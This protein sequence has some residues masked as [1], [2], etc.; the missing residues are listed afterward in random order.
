MMW[1]HPFFNMLSKREHLSNIKSIISFLFRNL[2]YYNELS[3]NQL[4]FFVIIVLSYYHQ[5]GYGYWLY[6]SSPVS[7]DLA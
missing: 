7:I 5:T 4:E 2:F 1:Y 6:M 3:S